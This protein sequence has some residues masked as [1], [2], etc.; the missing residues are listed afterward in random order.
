MLMARERGWEV[1]ELHVFPPEAVRASK[2]NASV[3]YSM[4]YDEKAG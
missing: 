1:Q 4:Q 2:W 3:Y